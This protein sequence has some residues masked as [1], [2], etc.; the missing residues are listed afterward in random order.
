[1]VYPISLHG[2]NR[3]IGVPRPIAVSQTVYPIPTNPEPRSPGLAVARAADAAKRP[4]SE[5]K[6]IGFAPASFLFSGTSIFGF[7]FNWLWDRRLFLVV[8]PRYSPEVGD[9]FV[10]RGTINCEN[11]IAIQVGCCEP[12]GGVIK[13]VSCPLK[14]LQ[15]FLAI[16]LGMCD[17]S[18]VNLKKSVC[19]NLG[20]GLL[21]VSCLT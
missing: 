13:S 15:F 5:V 10:G 11:G 12:V 4:S 14:Y 16:R 1:M 7:G 20:L 19:S 21:I 6:K 8:V 18:S 17:I 2:A 9:K 3:E